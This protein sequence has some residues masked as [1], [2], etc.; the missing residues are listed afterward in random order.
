MMTSKIMEA[1][2]KKEKVYYVRFV[3]S[4]RVGLIYGTTRCSQSKTAKKFKNFLTF[5]MNQKSIIR[6]GISKEGEAFYLDWELPTNSKLLLSQTLQKIQS[7]E[8]TKTLTGCVKHYVTS[9]LAP[10]F[11]LYSRLDTSSRKIKLE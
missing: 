4:C 3:S 5:K 10:I 11:P 1:F 2:I 7:F 8:Q 6:A 9:S